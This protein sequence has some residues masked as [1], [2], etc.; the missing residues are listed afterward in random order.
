M[1]FEQGINGS[2]SFKTKKFFVK[3]HYVF[4]VSWHSIWSFNFLGFCINLY[5]Y[6]QCKAQ[7]LIYCI[8]VI[9][10][11]AFYESDLNFPCISSAKMYAKYLT[12]V[13]EENTLRWEILVQR[14]A[15]CCGLQN[16]YIT[17]QDSL[18]LSQKNQNTWQLRSRGG[19]GGEEYFGWNTYC[20][21]V[22]KH[23]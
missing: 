21:F 5:R 3:Y 10:L 9:K 6:A 23:T 2:I 14:K 12:G 11:C 16:V 13:P 1:F 20:L 7:C 15:D 17:K 18:P 8:V 19:R 22:F 4:D